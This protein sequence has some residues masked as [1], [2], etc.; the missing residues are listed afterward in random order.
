MRPCLSNHFALAGDHVRA[1][2]YAMLAAQRATERF[3]HADAVRLYR[4]AIDAG[5]ALGP[6]ANGRGL[7]E[8]WEQL[9]EALRRVGEPAAASRAL[10][11]ARRLLRDDPIAQARLYDRQ[12]E[13]AERSEALSRAVRWLKR[14]LRV[15]DALDGD[16][17]DAQSRASAFTSGR[18][19]QSPGSVG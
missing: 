19:P 9:G 1:H 6:E 3:S 17:G 2:R 4:R 8:A 5:R 7:A 14:G 15:L 16:G 12:A 18:H 11:E 10:T 13:V